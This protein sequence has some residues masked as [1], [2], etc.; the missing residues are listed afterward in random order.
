MQI[1]NVTC[2]A[3]STVFVVDRSLYRVGTVPVRCASCTHYFLPEGSPCDLSIE[4]ATNSS[5]PITLYQPEME[6][7]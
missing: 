6:G 2:P 5:V 4:Q 3:C 1:A 7:R